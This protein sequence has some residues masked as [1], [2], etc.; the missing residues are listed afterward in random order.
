[1]EQD[2]KS[3]IVVELGDLEER[4]GFGCAVVVL[5]EQ[6]P[7]S[8][9][10][11]LTFQQWYLIYNE[12]PCDSTLKKAALARMTELADTFEQWHT[13]YKILPRERKDE[14][15]AHMAEASD[16]TFEA[17]CHIYRK[18]THEELAKVALIKAMDLAKTFQEW[19]FLAK[20][21][22][23]GSDLESKALAKMQ[24]LAVTFDEWRAIYSKAA[25]NGHLKDKALAKMKEISR[26]EG[27]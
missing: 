16:A 13:V 21:A 22:P 25:N 24:E 14:A 9:F 10:Q 6:L 18:T 26:K 5:E 12:A 20:E 7:E 3:K 15:L 17:W 1:M 23:L 27:I 8:F 19:C 11:S 4:Y 2:K